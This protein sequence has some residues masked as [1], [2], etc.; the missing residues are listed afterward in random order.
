MIISLI[1]FCLVVSI[2]TFSLP[3]TDLPFPAV[4]VCKVN[5]YDT[6]EYIRKENF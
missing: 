3:A 2:E 5:K 6:G 1:Q 4:T